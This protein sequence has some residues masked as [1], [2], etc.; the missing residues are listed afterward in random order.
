MGNLAK[1]I[2]NHNTK[3]AMAVM[4]KVITAEF[5]RRNLSN[6]IRCTA[7]APGYVATP[8]VKA[9]KKDILD[10]I[11][12]QIHLGRLI[13]PEEV[14]SLIFEIYRNKGLAGEVYFIHGGLRLGSKG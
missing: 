13:E 8:T 11:I 7:I 6:K 3:A 1:E 5:F 9:I 12:K 4:P 10:K 14:A 2:L